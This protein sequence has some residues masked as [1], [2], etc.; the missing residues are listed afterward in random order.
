MTFTKK[1]SPA[2][3]TG[4]TKWNPVATRWW[5]SSFC[6]DFIVTFWNLHIFLLEVSYLI[7]VVR[8]LCYF[9]GLDNSFVGQIG[10]IWSPTD[11]HYL[12]TVWSMHG[13]KFLVHSN[14]LFFTVWATEIFAGI[15]EIENIPRSLRSNSPQRT[16]KL[17]GSLVISS[18]PGWNITSHFL[19]HLEHCH[20]ACFAL[21]TSLK[22]FLVRTLHIF[23]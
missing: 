1:K 10:S 12:L 8:F 17:R 7:Q 11:V 4:P 3:P 14:H 22:S 20:I 18:D 15:C 23:I 21:L 2:A 19:L 16:G 9:I 6:F 5:S 13:V